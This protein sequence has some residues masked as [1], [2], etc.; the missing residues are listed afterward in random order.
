[1]RKA[2]NNRLLFVVFSRWEFASGWLWDRLD[3]SLPQF[4]EV[5]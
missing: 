3:K 1:M 4:V 2:A 5:D